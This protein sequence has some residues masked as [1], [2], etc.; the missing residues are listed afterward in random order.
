[1][2]PSCSGE[3]A[4]KCIDILTTDQVGE[5]LADDCLGVVAEMS[6]DGRADRLDV[7]G[8]GDQRRERC[9]VLHQHSELAVILAG[10]LPL[11]SIC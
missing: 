9:S 1:M 2:P 10:D 8:F 11:P 6:G 5:R 3:R 4:A 7:A